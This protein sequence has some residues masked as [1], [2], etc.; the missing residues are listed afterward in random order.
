MK[1][2]LCA[3]HGLPVK[4]PK[5]Q[6]RPLIYSKYAGYAAKITAYI[7]AGIVYAARVHSDEIAQE[8]LKKQRVPPHFDGGTHE[9]WAPVRFSPS[10]P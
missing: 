2:N 6:Q 10:S 3:D 5:N 4:G 8:R 9:R 7:I 1:S